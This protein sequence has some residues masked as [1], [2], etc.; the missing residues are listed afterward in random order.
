MRIIRRTAEIFQMAVPVAVLMA[1]TAGSRPRGERSTAWGIYSR[2][3]CVC[4][5]GSGSSRVQMHE[6]SLTS[7][8]F[9]ITTFNGDWRTFVFVSSRSFQWYPYLR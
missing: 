2:A 4:L 8:F 1:T 5:T 3:R 7:K 6:S 9:F